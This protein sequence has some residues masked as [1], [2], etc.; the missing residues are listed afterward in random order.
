[1]IIFTTNP[2]AVR[3]KLLSNLQVKSIKMLHIHHFAGI[4]ILYCNLKSPK[5]V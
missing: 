5:C 1:M 4:D 3:F 2:H